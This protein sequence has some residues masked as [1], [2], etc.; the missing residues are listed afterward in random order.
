MTRRNATK[1]NKRSAR[2][3]GAPDLPT[4]QAITRATK[5]G[6]SF[7][8]PGPSL[9]TTP[10][11][12]IYRFDLIAPSVK[13]YAMSVGVSAITDRI[14][15][16]IS[17]LPQISTFANLFDQYRI[18]QVVV[19]F[20]AK[21]TQVYWGN[22]SGDVP[23]VVTAIDYND[24]SSALAPAIQFQSALT[25]PMTT[26]FVRSFSPRVA[27]PVYNGVTDAYQMGPKDA[28]IDMRYPSVP[29]YQLLVEVGNTSIDNQ[30]VYNV[31]VLY[32]VEF[33]VVT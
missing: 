8:G 12:D 7:V 16:Q 15:F 3:R 22:S 11:M 14:N 27:I 23:K 28:W 17:D 30:F 24:N 1:R 31:D 18:K 13:R 29:H 19:S 4:T 20:T 2:R 26:S 32:T 10:Y 5:D 6:L 33:R 9:R 25:L 21:A